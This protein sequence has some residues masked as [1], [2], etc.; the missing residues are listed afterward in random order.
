[1]DAF[2]PLSNWYNP[3]V[4]GIDVGITMLMAENKRTGFIWDTFMKNKEAK[5][6]MVKAGFRASGA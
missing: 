2:N 4:I 3:D 5:A 6:A 1:V